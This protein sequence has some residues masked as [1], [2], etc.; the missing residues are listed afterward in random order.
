M[1]RRSL[2]SIAI[3]AVV[4]IALFGGNTSAQQSDD[5]AAIKAAHAGFLAAL[6]ARDAKAMQAV[7][8]NKPDVVNIGPRSKTAAVGYADAVSNYWPRT[9][10]RFSELKATAGSTAQVRSD[11][12]LAWLVGT[13][14]VTGTTKS[15]KAVK[16]ELFVTNLF[17]K[18]G[19]RWLLV[20]HHAHR[21]PR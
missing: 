13:E 14:R 19:G 3:A 2:L 1:N 21:I 20:S 9:F 11:G 7:W 16:F 8:A 15:G 12:K 17:E 4:G 6:S 10:A 18:I 5:V